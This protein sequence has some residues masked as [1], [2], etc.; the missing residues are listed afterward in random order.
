MEPTK[1]ILPTLVVAATSTLIHAQQIPDAGSLIP[2]ISR[3]ERLR[4]Q[5]DPAATDTRPALPP[6]PTIA[7]LSVQVKRFAF[8]GNTLFSAAQ[9]EPLVQGYL[10]RPLD[11]AA[12]QA[13]AAAVAEHYRQAGWV[14]RTYLPA[15]DL[16]DG[17]VTIQV[18]ETALGQL[19]FEQG[20]NTQLPQKQVERLFGSRLLPSQPLNSDQIDRAL[21]LANDLPGALVAVSLEE[22]KKAQTTD[23]VVKTS[24]KPPHFADI[25]ADNAGSVSTGEYRLSGNGEFGNLAGMADRLNWNW[26]HSEGSEFVKL[27]YNLPLGADGWRVG[28]NASTFDYRLTAQDLAPLRAAGSSS[29][30][31]VEL[32]YPLIRTRARNLK[33]TFNYDD[34]AFDNRANGATTTHYRLS[35]L[36]AG[37]SGCDCGTSTANHAMTTGSLQ[38]VGGYLNLGG[39]P[40]QATDASTVRAAGVYT[41][42]RYSLSYQQD[43]AR[44]LVGYVGWNGQIADKNL[45][46]SE[47]LYLGGPDGVRAFPSGEAGG[48]EGNVLSLELRWRASPDWVVTP[49]YDYGEVLVNRYNS[50]VGRAV[51]NRYALE[52]SGVALTWQ[53]PTG[54]SVKLSWARRS[55]PNPNPTATGTD[56]DGTHLF[57]RIWL[58]ANMVF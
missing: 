3:E 51:L 54:S 24:E 23:V 29:V 14:V 31:G 5:T 42:L 41:K 16:G 30:N 56:Q 40:N 12:L 58:S 52:G 22:G 1:S 32:T 47:K 57:D 21:L 49:F 26:I 34:K 55:Q 18:L 35:S 15:Q 9:L 36:S 53:S 39:S 28:L 44:E 20:A 4:P 8:A 6:L 38:L 17:V 13:A 50:F 19:R 10:N 45:D 25:T 2:Q 11:F 33:L 37:L 43:L 46:S 27:G 48:S 7:G